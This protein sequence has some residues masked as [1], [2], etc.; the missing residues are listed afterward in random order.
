MGLLRS[1]LSLKNKGFTIIELLIVMVIIAVLAA[2]VALSYTGITDYVRK[3]SFQTNAQ[4]ILKKMNIKESDGVGFDPLTIDET[5][6]FSELALEA[7]NYETLEV[8]KQN[9]ENY[10][11]ILGKNTFSNLIAC[12]THETVTVYNADEASCALGGGGSGIIVAAVNDTT[13]G[14]LGGGDGSTCAL[15]MTIDSIEDLAAFSISVNGGNNYSGKC[16]KLTTD[17]DFLQ[18]KSYMN[19]DATTFGLGN[20]PFGDING[21]STLE[22]IKTE[23]TT[24]A[25]FTPI[26]DSTHQ[27]SGTFNGTT[28]TI[29]DLTINRP[30][31]SYIGLFGRNISGNLMAINLNAVNIIGAEYTGGVAGYSENGSLT[32]SYVTGNITG[33]NRVGGVIG[34]LFSDGVHLMTSLRSNVNVTGADHV[35]GLV[36]YAHQNFPD[37]G[38]LSGVIIGGNIIA[39]GSNV[40]RAV[41]S[42]NAWAWGPVRLSALAIKTAVTVNGSTVTSSDN[43]AINGADI[44][45]MAELNSIALAELALDTYIGGDNDGNGYYWDLDGS[46]LVRKNTSDNPLTFGLAGAGTVGDPY[47]IAN[48]TDLKQAAL[49]LDK[50]YKLTADINLNGQTFYM[51]GLLVILTATQ[52]LSVI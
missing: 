16:I 30:S 14:T 26:G 25:G 8:Y 43:T 42:Q 1:K 7:T 29:Y 13:P 23:L 44:N 11:H 15:A 33:S 31:T 38:T 34:S 18:N 51:L 47:Q 28:H 2:I 19:P 35:G 6:L 36:G 39:T 12:G 48:Y 4:T 49:K 37:A 32:E 22:G 50:A 20:T 3:A 27:F 10:I 40:G 45:N 5:N 17:L 46:N 24:A 52:K 41:G 9:S 21:N